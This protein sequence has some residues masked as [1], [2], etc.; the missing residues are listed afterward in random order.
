MRALITGI[1]GFVGSHLAEYCLGLGLEVHGTI[2]THHLGD[3]LERI[4]GIRDKIQ[5]HECDLRNRSRVFSVIRQV[6]PDQIF[7]LAAQSFVPVSW[8]DPEGTI[9]NNVLSELNIFE[10]CRELKMYSVIQIAGSS[11]EYGIVKPN[12]CPIKETNP[13]RPASPYAVSKVAQ[14]MLGIQYAQSYGMKI[15]ITRAFNHEGPRRG[16]LFV[17]SDFASQ[18]VDIERGKQEPVIK[19]G[20]LEAWRDYTDVRDV[21][22]AYSLAVK[23]CKCGEPY[24]ISSGEKHQIR[25]LLGALLEMTDVKVKIQQDPAKIRPSDVPVLCGDSSK[26]REVTG[27]KPQVGF[28][29]MLADILQYWREK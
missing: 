16:K 4:K 14:E 24:N 3:E 1:T 20:N 19:V 23:H 27:W 12:E 13:L 7:H 29:T 26:F 11:E 25:E 9:L 28:R 10:V 15:V 6:R 21:V 18:I 17:T 5:L 8:Q 22:R 2:R